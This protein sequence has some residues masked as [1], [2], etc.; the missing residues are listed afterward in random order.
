MDKKVESRLKSVEYHLE[1]ASNGDSHSAMV[2]HHAQADI[3]NID[4][5]YLLDLVRSQAVEIEAKT[6]SLN[7]VG[8]VVKRWENGE[9]AG[10]EAGTVWREPVWPLPPG[11]DEIR[12]A[13]KEGLD[14]E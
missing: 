12:T 14:N 6:K 10:T 1:V 13:L 8:D 3:I 5:P 11:T 9:L 7:I 4:V 2:V